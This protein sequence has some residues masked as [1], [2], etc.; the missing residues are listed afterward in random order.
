MIIFFNFVETV[1]KPSDFVTFVS[2]DQTFFICLGQKRQ[3]LNFSVFMLKT[4]FENVTYV[5]II[6]KLLLDELQN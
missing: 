5:C 6:A 2:Q 4:F 1:S 3:T